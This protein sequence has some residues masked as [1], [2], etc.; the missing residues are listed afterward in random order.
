M[1]PASEWLPQQ[2]QRPPTPL[3]LEEQH[4]SPLQANE[5]RLVQKAGPRQ[6]LQQPSRCWV[7]IIQNIFLPWSIS[8]SFWGMVTSLNSKTTASLLFL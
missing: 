8:K 6:V 2:Q 3:C 1:E 7:C 5:E 4:P